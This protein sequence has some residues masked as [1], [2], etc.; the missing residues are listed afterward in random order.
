MSLAGMSMRV[1][2][3][4]SCATTRL[5]R[6]VAFA[7][8]FAMLHFPEKPELQDL[9]DA[10]GIHRV[11]FARVAR[12]EKI[13]GL[14]RK[15]SR[16]WKLVNRKAFLGWA[17]GY[18][19]RKFL[20]CYNLEGVEQEK[21]QNREAGERMQRRYG[22]PALPESVASTPDGEGIDMMTTTELARELGVTSQTVRNWRR[23]IPGAQLVGH[24]LR[25][26]RSDR[27]DRWIAEFRRS[28]NGK[29]NDVRPLEQQRVKR[30][31]ESQRA[32]PFI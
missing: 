11:S 1:A 13:P 18:R 3:R 27:L 7:K 32:L 9:A 16:R 26:K 17:V 22:L 23:R 2:T 10:L 5:H 24:R 31:T 4:L 21:R 30:E 19:N 15:K 20:R 29:R 25:I 28:S 8:C 12:T 6:G 14:R